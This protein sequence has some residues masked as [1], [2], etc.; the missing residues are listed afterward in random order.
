MMHLSLEHRGRELLHGIDLLVNCLRLPSATA[1][2][3]VGWWRDLR[4]SRAALA[5]LHVA[6]LPRG[7][8]K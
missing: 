7:S 3:R 1:A 4:Q 8:R 6:G 2:E 5:A